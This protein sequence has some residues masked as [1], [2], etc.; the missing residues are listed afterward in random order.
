MQLHPK[1]KYFHIGCDEVYQLGQCSKCKDRMRKTPVSALNNR[2]RKNT[3]MSDMDRLSMQEQRQQ[4]RPGVD[5]SSPRGLFLDHVK[6]VARYVKENYNI[7]VG[8]LASIGIIWS[9]YMVTPHLAYNLGWHAAQDECQGSP[10]IRYCSTCW[11]H[12]MGLCWG[13]WS[14]CGWGHLAY[15]LDCLSPSVDCFSI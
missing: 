3:T 11:A 7:Q 8:S 15:L 2:R 6:R 9:W 13:H 12:G 4:I 14:L 5:I 10:S 1:V